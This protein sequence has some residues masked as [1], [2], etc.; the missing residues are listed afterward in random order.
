MAVSAAA[1]RLKPLF[2]R[3][4]VQRVD[5]IKKIGS[6]YIPDSAMAK[7]SEGHVVATGPGARNQAGETLPLTVKPGDKV[8]LPEYGGDKI[9]LDKVE[10]I[11]YREAE[12]LGVLSE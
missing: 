11:M 3:V 8:L 7:I 2:D 1:A 4:L 5:A 6:V 10:Y 12:L 9:E